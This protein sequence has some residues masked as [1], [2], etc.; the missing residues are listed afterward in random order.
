M[1]QPTHIVADR[2]AYPHFREADP[3][4]HQVQDGNDAGAGSQPD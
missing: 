1:Y 4:L 3:A 2:H